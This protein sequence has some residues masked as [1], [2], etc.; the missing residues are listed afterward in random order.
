MR[1]GIDAVSM[2]ST[3]HVCIPNHSAFKQRM[4]RALKQ[5]TG[6]APEKGGEP[7][8]ANQGR[9]IETLISGLH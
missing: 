2:Y 7:L 5:T 8:I 9:L 3:V 4:F 6:N 1:I